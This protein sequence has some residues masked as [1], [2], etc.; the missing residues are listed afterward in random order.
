MK[1]KKESVFMMKIFLKVFFIVLM[2]FIVFSIGK[3]HFS[4]I[5]HNVFVNNFNKISKETPKCRLSSL[6]KNRR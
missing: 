4:G 2:V 3:L 5:N 6:A 1:Q